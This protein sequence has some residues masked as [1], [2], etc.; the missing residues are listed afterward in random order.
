MQSWAIIPLHGPSHLRNRAVRLAPFAP[1]LNPTAEADDEA[2]ATFLYEGLYGPCYIVYYDRFTKTRVWGDLIPESRLDDGLHMS[3]DTIF[4][5]ERHD[6]LERGVE[7]NIG[8]SRLIVRGRLGLF[9]PDPNQ[10][11]VQ[12]SDGG[13]AFGSAGLFLG[14]RAELR[15]SDGTIVARTKTSRFPQNAMSMDAT[16]GEV[17]LNLLL[18]SL[19]G[20]LRHPGP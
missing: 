19:A 18:F 17:A 13:Y 11:T 14:G 8:G 3:P 2:F 4:G 20:W 5:R 16:P 1:W 6:K 7:G 10:V 12:L 15:R 9:L